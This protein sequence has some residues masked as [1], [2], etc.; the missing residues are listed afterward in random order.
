M[1]TVLETDG[2][3][4][5]LLERAIAEGEVRIKRPNGDV[6]VLRPDIA[7][8]RA[9]LD[10]ESMDLGLSTKEIIEVVREGRERS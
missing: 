10:V 3:L 5:E 7:K 9:S 2:E 8:K 6:F 1:Q 4:T